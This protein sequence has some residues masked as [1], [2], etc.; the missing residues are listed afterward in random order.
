MVFRASEAGAAIH[1]CVIASLGYSPF[2]TSMMPLMEKICH[3]QSADP[4]F[5]I[6]S[7]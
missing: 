3:P 6:I 7:K 5:A 4:D 2:G 1:Q